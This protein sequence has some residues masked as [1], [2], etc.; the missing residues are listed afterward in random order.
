M[1]PF[2]LISSFLLTSSAIVASVHYYLWRRK[3]RDTKLKGF[4]RATLTS[5]YI[6]GAL[7]VPTAFLLS[8]KIPKETLSPFVFTAFLWLGFVFYSFLT[9]ALW[10]AFRVFYHIKKWLQT[11]LKPVEPQENQAFSAD[12]RVFLS[13]A[14][15]ATALF[16]A[17]GVSVFGVQ[18]AFGE[19]ASPEIP[20]RLARLPSSMSGFTIAL[21][22]D[23]HIGQILGRDFAGYVVERTNALKPDLIAITGDV[24]DGPCALLKHDVAPLGRLKAPYGVYF[25]TGN[26]EYYSGVQ[27]WLAYFRSMGFHILANQRVSIGQSDS[28]ELAGVYDAAGR[29]FGQKPDL[30]KA[31]EGIDPESELILL[32]HRP[33][34]IFQAAQAGVGLQ[35]SGHTHGGQLWPLEYVVHLNQPYVAGL[36][37]HTPLTQIYVTRGAGFWGPPMRALAPAEITYITLFV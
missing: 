23:L 20:V 19:I 2:L 30:T 36:H 16:T 8:R 34:V 10:D 32:A 15:A 28:F 11:R 12:R 26:H 25:V 7:M 21:L 1:M 31:L 6:A 29:L 13:Q 17:G 14:A 33:A 37:S 18:S 3:V 4:W 5:L 22:S 9:L 24:V 27:E 35:L